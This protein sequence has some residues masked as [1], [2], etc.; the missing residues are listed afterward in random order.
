VKAAP[1]AAAGTAESNNPGERP[2][3]AVNPE[4]LRQIDATL[5]ATPPQVSPGPGDSP[6]SPALACLPAE[7]DPPLTREAWEGVLRVPFRLLATYSQAPRVADVG[8]ARAKDLAKPSY[9][10]FEHYARE[11]CALNPD[12]PL[13]LAWA[14]TAL[15]LC[16]I[17]A[18]VAVEI[19]RA[20]AERQ[21]GL[22][23]GVPGEAVVHQ[24]AA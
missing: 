17:G 20:R 10:I 2:L 22:P 11:Y 13:S 16:D 9:I 8:N 1:T 19:A 4:F 15:V 3:P 24:Q 21:R 7:T 12:N 23:A 5:G 14:A 18:D 6:E